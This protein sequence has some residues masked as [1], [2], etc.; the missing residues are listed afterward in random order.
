MLPS[1]WPAPRETEPGCR[2]DGAAAAVSR[3]LEGRLQGQE[4]EA[5]PSPRPQARCRG[6]MNKANKCISWIPVKGVPLVWACGIRCAAEPASPVA[7]AAKALVTG[8][9]ATGSYHVE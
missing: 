5:Q 1:A 9:V 8:V 7:R 2:C 6:A 4:L 3:P